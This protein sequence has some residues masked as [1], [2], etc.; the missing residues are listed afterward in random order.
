MTVI[1]FSDTKT[2]WEIW[3]PHLEEAFAELGLTPELTH[4]HARTDITHIALAPS[5]FIEDYRQFPQLQAVFSTWAGVEKVVG[6]PTLTVPLT[7]MVE[8]GLS[9]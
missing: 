7:H 5:G 6:N 4:D 2:Q 1:L 8:P 3:R 9:T